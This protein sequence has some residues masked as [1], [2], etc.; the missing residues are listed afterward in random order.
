MACASAPRETASAPAK[1]VDTSYVR[2][3]FESAAIKAARI[4]E[5][6]NA[7]IHVVLPASYET[8]TT[9]RYPVVYALHGFGDGALSILN[10]LRRP[11]TQAA[12][13]GTCPEVI[14]VAIEGGNSLGGSFYLNS[15][16]TGN[17]ED[18]VV[19]ETVQLIDAR[20][21]TITEA[22]ARM[23][24]GYSM[25]GFGA[26]NIAIAH[27]D[28]FGSGWASCPGAWDD[29]G[30]VDTLRTWA[31]IYRVAYGAA[32]APDFTLSAPYAGIPVLDGS[33]ADRKLRSAWE[34]GFGDS[35]RKVA[36]YAKMP[37]KLKGIRF[38]YGSYDSFGWIPRGTVHVAN[39]MKEGG[40]PVEI[41]EHG[42][43]HVVSDGMLREGLIP[44]ASRMFAGY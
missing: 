18:L 16:A 36:E 1:P 37:A 34:R 40:L 29:N 25:G 33:E 44:F 35:R 41:Q 12:A 4:P 19:R 20:F 7:E 2:L 39:V 32:L 10:I 24:A 11:L 15:P 22:G 28:V 13:A 23:I 5:S 30:L 42:V 31:P 21:R 8:A 27:P 9:K 3:T 26:W 17:W 14:L 43:G 38:E 6:G